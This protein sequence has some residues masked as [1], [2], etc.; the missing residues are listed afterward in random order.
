LEKPRPG[1][2]LPDLINWLIS[3]FYSE[4]KGSSNR[5]S[6]I[7]VGAISAALLRVLDEAPPASIPIDGDGVQRA[8]A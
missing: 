7:P 2:P 8:G 6:S 3:A 4:T 1:E 5:L